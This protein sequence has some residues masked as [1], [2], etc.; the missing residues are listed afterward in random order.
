[1]Q[2]LSKLLF[3]LIFLGFLIAFMIKDY[4]MGYNNLVKNPVIV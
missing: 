2:L 1:V 3:A 4:S